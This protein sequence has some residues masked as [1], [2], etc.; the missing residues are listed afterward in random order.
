MG[1]VVAAKIV[2]SWALTRL[3][4]L[5]ARPLQLAIG[6]GQVGEFSYVLGA[7]AVTAG[8][9][10]NQLETALVAAVA[11]TIAGSSV[12]VRVAGQTKGHRNAG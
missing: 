9:I 4:R 1:L 10:T 12:L 11:I 5:H 2:P 8:I 3:G 6:L 7:L